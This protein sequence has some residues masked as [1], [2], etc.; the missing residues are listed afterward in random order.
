M[1]KLADD[2][3]GLEAEARLGAVEDG[4]IVWGGSPREMFGPK[5][6][7]TSARRGEPE[8]VDSREETPEN[9]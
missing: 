1:E 9:A 4:D 8:P 3:A 6:E 2:E 7:V 5:P